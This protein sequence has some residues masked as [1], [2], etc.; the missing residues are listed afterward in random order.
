MSDAIRVLHDYLAKSPSVVFPQDVLEFLPAI[1][2]ENDKLVIKLNAEHI[3]RLNV[4]AEN[5]KLRE[6]VA[7]V[8]EALCLDKTSLF[9]EAIIKSLEDDMR[10]LGI[11]VE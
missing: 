7:D 5:S 4:E 1:K 3:V 11:E 2:A 10:E 9:R 8:R 6:L